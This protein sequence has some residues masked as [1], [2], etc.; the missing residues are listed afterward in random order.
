MNK[1][2][3]QATLER[4][5]PQ[6]SKAVNNLSIY[7]ELNRYKYRCTMIIYEKKNFILKNFLFNEKNSYFM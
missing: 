2:L 1:I 3:F 5:I 7:I 6:V 4:V